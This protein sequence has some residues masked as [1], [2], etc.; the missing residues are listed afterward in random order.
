VATHRPELDKLLEHARPGDT[1]VIWRLDR[2]GRSMK[3]LLELIDGR[4]LRGIQ[5]DRADPDQAAVADGAAVVQGVAQYR[6]Q[7]QAIKRCS[8]ADSRGGV[9]SVWKMTQ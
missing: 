9:R 4:R 8:V 2:L 3:H 7:N 5:Q 1:V 6:L